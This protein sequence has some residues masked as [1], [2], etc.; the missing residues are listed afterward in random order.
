M[1]AT[2]VPVKT[3]PKTIVLLHALFKTP[4]GLHKLQTTLQ[5]YFP[6]VNTI[7]PAEVCT[8]EKSIEQQATHLLEQ[9]QNDYKIDQEQAVILVGYSQGGLRGHALLRQY[10]TQLNIN[11]LIAINT[12]WEG[13]PAT[14]CSK[15]IVQ[16]FL[17]SIEQSTLIRLLNLLHR[18]G[19][20]AIPHIPVQQ[21]VTKFKSILERLQH[22]AYQGIVDLQPGSPFLEATA[23]QLQTN[24]TPILALAGGPSNF[25]DAAFMSSVGKRVVEI[26]IKKYVAK[27]ERIIG[28]AAHDLVIPVY[29]Q[30]A[31]HLCPANGTFFRHAIPHAIHGHLMDTRLNNV[32]LEHPQVLA[33]M[34][35]FIE[36]QWGLTAEQV[37]AR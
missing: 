27:L 23:Q 9:L 31:E 1:S 18:V 6:E 13:V 30:L 5:Q 2:Q 15:D 21:V 20:R 36:Q 10:G 33:K 3:Q 35:A 8:E 32:A 24:T 37:H 22:N 34:I 26:L 28:N 14:I 7:A 29:S 25:S 17:T 16:S 11:A 12:P 19:L 4:K